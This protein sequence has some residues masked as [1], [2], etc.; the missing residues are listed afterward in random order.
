M[1]DDPFVLEPVVWFAVLC[2]GVG[3][4]KQ[5]RINLQG[6]FSQVRFFV[7]PDEKGIHPHAHVQGVLAMGFSG[8]E[9]HFEADI[10][11]LDIDEQVLWTR[12]EKWGFDVGLG[13]KSSAVLGEEVN[14][15]LTA[16]GRYH[17]LIRLL[18]GRVQHQIPFEVAERIGPSQ[19]EALPQ[20]EPTE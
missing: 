3:V 13:A 9:G 17:F 4:D 10:Q 7:P 16:P 6:V 15:W 14:L 1:N 12:P 11:L 19:P 8:G 20:E 18:P 2:N 5:G